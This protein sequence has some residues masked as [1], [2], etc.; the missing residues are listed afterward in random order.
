MYILSSSDTL[1]AAKSIEYDSLM[2]AEK[3]SRN[4]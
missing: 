2:M 4:M 3:V 1:Q